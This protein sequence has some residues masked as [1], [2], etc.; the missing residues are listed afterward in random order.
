M[1][2][3]GRGSKL[4]LENTTNMVCL[5]KVQYDKNNSLLIPL[6]PEQ[7]P[8]LSEKASLGFSDTTGGGLLVNGGASVGELYLLT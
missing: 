3:F 1:E 5:R 6:L 4:H 8:V 7:R 2:Y